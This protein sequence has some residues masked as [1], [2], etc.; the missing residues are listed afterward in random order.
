MYIP[1][2]GRIVGSGAKVYVVDYSSNNASLKF[3]TSTG[4]S[5]SAM[6]LYNTSVYNSATGS[7]LD[8]GPSVMQIAS[9]SSGISVFYAYKSA[10]STI[11]TQENKISIFTPT[12]STPMSKSDY[13][14]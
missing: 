8:N 13:S 4:S 12:G 9:G 14:A 3:A 11:P 5:A 6:T 7:T 10:G 2:S 1:Q